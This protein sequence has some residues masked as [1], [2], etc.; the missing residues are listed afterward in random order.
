MVKSNDCDQSNAMVFLKKI[1]RLEKRIHQLE[2][3]KEHIYDGL[4]RLFEKIEEIGLK[5]K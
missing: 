3:E 1:E 4:E 5:I 2:V